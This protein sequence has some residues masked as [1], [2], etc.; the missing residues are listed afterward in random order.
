MNKYVNFVEILRKNYKNPYI[1]H[2]ILL[3]LCKICNIEKIY[4]N[5]YI[6]KKKKKNNWRDRFRGVPDEYE[7]QY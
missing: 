5:L 6:Q 4:N 3:T 1:L 2:Q 7:L